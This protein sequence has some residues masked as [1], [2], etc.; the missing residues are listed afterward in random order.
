MED[1]K[2][3]RAPGAPE[4]TSGGLWRAIWSYL[5]PSGCVFSSSPFSQWRTPRPPA[6]AP[7]PCSPPR[8]D[9]NRPVPS[10]SLAL[11]SFS[12]V[13]LL[14]CQRVAGSHITRWVVWS[15]VCIAANVSSSGKICTPP[16]HPPKTM[17]LPTHGSASGS[18]CAR[19]PSRCASLEA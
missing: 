2:L 13:C 18:H 9:F 10:T 8:P 19:Y 11:A 6:P 7:P 5:S 16:W 14:G 4:W 15:H 17:L 1:T 12:P 3:G